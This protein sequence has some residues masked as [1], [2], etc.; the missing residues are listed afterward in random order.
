MFQ[1]SFA[2]YVVVGVTSAALEMGL[3]I[4]FVKK[5][6]LSPLVGNVFAF[7]ITCILNYVLSRK[8]VFERT[9]ERKRVEF[10]LFM[11]FV[12]CGLL[13]SQVVM[14]I[15]IDLWAIDFRVA[16]VVAIGFVV[17]WNFFTRKH[18]VFNRLDNLKNL[19]SKR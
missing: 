11:F 13:I 8:W 3:L 16:K 4:I 19:F 2:R 5:F 15:G 10:F 17:I 1:G 12:T 7:M 9:G 18:F 14:W 6:G